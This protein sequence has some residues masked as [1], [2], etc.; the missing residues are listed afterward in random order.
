[1]IFILILLVV[2]FTGRTYSQNNAKLTQKESEAKLV[3]ELERGVKYSNYALEAGYSGDVILKF[4]VNK[5]QEIVDLKIVKG[6]FS[7]CDSEVVNKLILYK[8][9]VELKPKT[10]N[11]TASFASIMQ[12]KDTLNKA[13]FAHVKN[14]SLLHV[15]I[16]RYQ[17]VF[18]N[19]VAY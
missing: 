19:E 11:L 5:K 6:F 16:V 12:N 8:K 15:M 17:P 7:L 3:S 1:M 2:L 4:S 13:A 9:D 18:K 10:Y 14:K